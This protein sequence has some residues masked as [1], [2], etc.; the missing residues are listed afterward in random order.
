MFQNATQFGI[1]RSHFTNV[2]GDVNIHP[3]PVLPD[4]SQ[5]TQPSGLN[6]PDDVHTECEIYCSQLQRKGRG[7]PLYVPNSQSNLPEEYQKRGIAIG[8]VGSVTPE[9][10]FDFYFNIYLSSN[11]PINENLVPEE[12][13]P[14]PIYLERDTNHL[15][16]DPGEYVASPSVHQIKNGFP[17]GTRVSIQLCRSHRCCLGPATWCTSRETQKSGKLAT[18]C[19]SPC[20]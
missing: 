3:T 15:D 10:I 5:T 4:Q 8:D 6:V 2:A 12:F 17:S 18:L 14:F 13:T 11:H 9:G 1:E 19:N 7:F 20:Q 16:Y